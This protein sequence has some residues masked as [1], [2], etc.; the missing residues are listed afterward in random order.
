MAKITTY[1]FSAILFIGIFTG[2]EKEY[3]IP[4]QLS[5][6]DTVSFKNEIIP[7]FTTN[8]AISGCHNSGGLSPVLEAPVAYDNLFNGG[9]IALSAGEVDTLNAESSVIYQKINTGSMAKYIQKPED[10][11]KILNW[12]KQGALDN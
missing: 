11:V 3:F 7:I 8:C 1:I 9:Y 6:D 12:I 10:R 4:V 2:C 5:L